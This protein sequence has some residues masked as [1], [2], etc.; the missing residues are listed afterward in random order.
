MSAISKKSPRGI[1]LP[2]LPAV[3]L[4][5]ALICPAIAANPIFSTE[6]FTQHDAILISDQTGKIIYQWQPDKALVPASLTKLVTAYLAIDKWGRDHRFITDFFIRGNELWVKGY[7]DP[8][9]IS[10]ELDVIRHALQDKLPNGIKSLHVDSS[11][12]LREPVPGQTS[13]ADP[14][15]AP[16]SAVAANFNTVMLQRIAGKLSSA[17]PQTPLTDVAAQV[18]SGVGS[19]AERVN[20]VDVNRA[21]HHFAELLIAKM[22]LGIADI[23]INQALPTDAEPVYRHH[24][25]HPLAEVLRGALEYSN[26]FIANQLFLLLAQDDEVSQMQFANSAQYVK[27]RLAALMNWSSAVLVDGSGLSRRNKLTAR[28]I[29]QVLRSLEPDKLLLKQY[30]LDE[31]P[32]S[33][34]ISPKAYA[35]SGTLSGV[36]GLAGYLQLNGVQ[37][38]FVFMFNRPM[39]YRYREQLLQKLAQQLALSQSMD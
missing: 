9:L 27:E 39:S 8:Y 11:Y 17:E 36:H 21:Q 5:V 6:K 33:G 25:S 15:N 19:A 10:E 34:L 2:V 35:K 16:L 24:N 30:S 32:G 12:F 13:V 23:H 28:Q 1:H 18:A 22:G 26:N 31:N 38:Q 4:L 20:L 7:G 29:N 3:S 14:Y 37:Y